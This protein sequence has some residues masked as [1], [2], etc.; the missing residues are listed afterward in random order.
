MIAAIVL[1]WWTFTSQKEPDLNF[2]ESVIPNRFLRHCGDLYAPHTVAKSQTVSS[3]SKLVG[4]HVDMAK[5]EHL[6][7]KLGLDFDT[8]TFRD[9]Y[10]KKYVTVVLGFW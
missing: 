3:N 7:T 10:S 1:I 2:S 6:K 5:K 4:F 9:Y 8:A